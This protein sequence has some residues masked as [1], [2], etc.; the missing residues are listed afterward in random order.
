MFSKIILV[1]LTFLYTEY[2]FA[3]SKKEGPSLC[4]SILL[5]KSEPTKKHY[6]LSFNVDTST[7]VQISWISFDGKLMPKTRHMANGQRWQ[8]NSFYNHWWIFTDKSNKCLA[9]YSAQF[10]SKI[11]KISDLEIGLKNKKN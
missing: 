5:L 11:T 3:I 10:L 6:N 2:S 7:P 8:Q 9:I 1:I 4:D